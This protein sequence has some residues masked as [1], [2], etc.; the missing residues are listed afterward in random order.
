MA[1]ELKTF[2]GSQFIGKLVLADIE[3]IPHL[4]TINDFA[5]TNGLKIYVTSSTRALGVPVQGAVIT[6]A[7]MS[8]HFIGH[9]IDMNIQI[10]ST[11]YNSN[12]LGNFSSLPAAI[13]AFITAIRNHPVLRWGGDFGDP[14]HID[15][16]L[17]NNNPSVWKQKL[18]IIQSE[19]TGL[20]QP[21]IRTGSGPRLLFLTTPLMEG[22]DVKAV[23]KKLIGRGFDLGKNGADGLFGQATVNAVLKFQDQEDLEP[24]DGIVGDKTREALGL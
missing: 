1:T 10:G 6:P 20:T 16:N 15:D 7:K 17:N 23:Q 13:K 11:L 14:V 19:L 3:F 24:V 21:G 4:E 12:A 8:N 18:P 2:T 9:G 5:T 22:D